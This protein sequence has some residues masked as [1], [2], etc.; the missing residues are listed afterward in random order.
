MVNNHSGKKTLSLQFINSSVKPGDNFYRYANGRW[1]DTA[2]VLPW[3]SRAGARLE[4]DYLTKS[5]IQSILE[6]ASKADSP[7]GSIVQKVGDFYASGMD[8]VSIDK[9]GYRPVLHFLNQI[10]S[11]RNIPGMMQWVASQWTINAPILIGQIISPDDKNSSKNLVIYYQAGIGLPERDYYFRNDAATK[12]I[13]SAYQQYISRLF[14]LVGED[15]SMARNHTLTV[16]GIERKMADS[17]RTNVELRDV[18]LNYNK[19]SLDELDK[20]MPNIGWRSLT[21]NLQVETDSVNLAQ[22]GYYAE[23]NEL[24][25]SIPLADWKV[26]L[27][28]HLLD[29]YAPYLSKDF[30]QANF[31]FFGKALSGQEQMKM[32]WE[33]VYQTIDAEFGEGLGQLYVSKYFSPEA[34]QR[35]VEL[36]NNLK[37]AFDHRIANLSWM[38]DSTKSK[39][40]DKLR[41]VRIKVGYPDKWKD[42]SQV[43][44]DRHDYLENVIACGKFEYQRQVGKIGKPADRDEWGMTPETND[45]YNNGLFN[46]IVFPAGILQ[47]PLFDMGSDDAMNYGGI[48]MVIGHELTHGFD[49]QG[50]LYDKDGN[51]HNWWASDDY[52]KFSEREDLVVKQYN[53]FTVLDS[54]HVNGRLTLGENT[55]DMGGLAIAYDAFKLTS[56]G[57]DTTKIDGLSPDQRF[58][59]SFAQCWRKKL[60]DE[61]LRAQVNTDPHSPGDF[62]VLGPLMNFTPFYEAYGLKPGD[63][64]YKPGSERISVW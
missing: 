48:G 14:R 63:K 53:A 51:M 33:R 35:M 15:S 49:D 1:L 7:R 28:F 58:F 30:E 2:T 55:A 27:K 10:D 16:I 61:A 56:S 29:N 37:E 46:E 44:I 13:V 3:E 18:K 36:V 34:K 4:M 26:Y 21:K 8:T 12:A 6:E 43:N 19:K 64:M 17:H 31:D 25:R 23:L 62:R 54:L 32:R 9:L 50:A 45:A 52:K 57:K 11:I 60:R 20:K 41:H 24:L 38:S 42:Y 22:P 40:R 5:H 59:L 39:A 47:F